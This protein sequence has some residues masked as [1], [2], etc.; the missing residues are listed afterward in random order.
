VKAAD[1]T[2]RIGM[3]SPLRLPQG[4]GT[5]IAETKCIR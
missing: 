1:D 2:V 5:R 4:G 3:K